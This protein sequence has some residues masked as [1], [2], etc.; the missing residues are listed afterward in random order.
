M[1]VTLLA[2]GS[3]DLIPVIVAA[4]GLWWVTL[5]LARRRPEAYRPAAL[6]TAFVVAGGVAKA[7]SKL[8]AASTGSGVPVVLDQS[9]FPLLAPGMLLLALATS[10][11]LS[12]SR[13]GALVWMVPFAVWPSAAVVGFAVSWSAGKGALIAL[14]TV[15]NVWLAVALVRWASQL[16]LRTSAALFAVNLVVVIGL[17]GLA[18]GVDQTTAW[19]WIE[20]NTNLAA[21][22]AFLL[23][24]R[25]L[26]TVVEWRPAPATA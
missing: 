12:E 13:M 6:G 8:I 26:R 22:I 9:L 23:A 1:D 24:A 20:Q 7:G 17:A 21:Q 10:T 4:V 3:H 25:R 16:G 19:Q 2:L 18:R 5:A 15:G 11:K 14:A